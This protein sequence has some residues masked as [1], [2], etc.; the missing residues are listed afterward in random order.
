MAHHYA[1][2]IP[3]SR[4]PAA[5][6]LEKR[7]TNQ[8]GKQLSHQ[9]PKM[10]ANIGAK[11]IHTAGSDAFPLDTLMVD[12]LHTRLE[13]FAES[14]D[15]VSHVRALSKAIGIG[16]LALGW[17][18]NTA[19]TLL[20]I[21]IPIYVTLG[22][23]LVGVVAT[24]IA[25]ISS[26]KSTVR[27]WKTMETDVLRDVGKNMARWYETI[28]SVR[29]AYTRKQIRFAEDYFSAVAADAR[30]RMAMFVGALE[31][32]GLIPLLGTV[33]VT[34][35]KSTGSDPYSLFLWYTAA[36][37]AGIFYVFALRFIEIALALERFTVILRHAGEEDEKL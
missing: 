3:R 23:L 8:G 27:E 22:L 30:L 35:A 34:I 29:R 9:D 28:R 16:A 2:A 11:H 15:E 13:G 19:T 12:L 6:A 17:A 33:V 31:K 32:V 14:Q 36:A 18:G 4:T 20:K 25:S 10:L 5:N 1:E 37:V 24:V 21:P 26:A 7:F